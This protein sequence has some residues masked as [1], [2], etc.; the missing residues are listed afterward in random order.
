MVCQWNETE[1]NLLVY[2]LIDMSGILFYFWLLT[3]KAANDFVYIQMAVINTKKTQQTNPNPDVLLL[4]YENSYALKLVAVPSTT[5]QNIRNNMTTRRN[6][7]I[8]KEKNK[9]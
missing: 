2:I 6:L 9:S 4:G 8:N 5:R 1:R 3:G 7:P